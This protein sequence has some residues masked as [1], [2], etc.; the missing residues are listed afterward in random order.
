MSNGMLTL[1]E[2]MQYLDLDKENVEALI[3][4]DKLNAYKIGGVY[5]RFRKDQVVQLHNAFTAKH[6]KS[7]AVVRRLYNF[8]DF[9]NFY[10]ITA[11]CLI[12]I[13]YFVLH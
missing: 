2:V 5:L 7:V 4:Q 11:A 12:G 6:S 8:W 13:L 10:I 1:N 3:H 9:N